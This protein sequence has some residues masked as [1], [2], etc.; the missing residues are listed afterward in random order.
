[1]GKQD[2]QGFYYDVYA[3]NLNVI[4]AE[5][6]EFVC[7]C[8]NPEHIDTHPSAYFNPRSGLFFC[9]SCGFSANIYQV[10]ELT[11]GK[12]VK[13][14]SNNSTNDFSD[15]ED[16]W[17]KYLTGNLATKNPYLIK[18]NIPTNLIEQ[19]NIQEFQGGISFP[20][21]NIFNEVVGVQIRYTRANTKI[22]YR[23]FGDKTIWPKHNLSEYDFSKP[24][25][26]TE[27]IFGAL[28][29]IKNGYQAFT[30]FG[31]E[32]IPKEYQIG[33]PNLI[34]LFD[35]DLAG[36]LASMNLL[37]FVPNSKIYFPGCEADELS[38]KQW[39]EIQN[40]NGLTDDI[41]LLFE[42]INN[43]KVVRNNLARL[44]KYKNAK[45]FKR[46]A[47]LRGSFATK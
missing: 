14:N 16:D 44:D 12:I 42:V 45:S 28:N 11:D 21:Y 36:Y 39:T 19:F 41:N 35:N 10:A 32:N 47:K 38:G 15:T 2:Y 24:V 1:M 13:T 4:R 18:R 26:I 37:N 29:A 6:G 3:L 9:H 31:S 23:Y 25:Y 30:I 20:I 8:I 27:G 46:N 5:S 40:G 43:R 7:K 34:G 17:H 33:F 22:R